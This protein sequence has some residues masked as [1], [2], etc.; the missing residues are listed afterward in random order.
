MVAVT[1]SEHPLL[2]RAIKSPKWLITKR[3]AFVLRPANEFRAQAEED[4]SVLLFTNCT[5][6]VCDVGARKCVGEFVLKTEAVIA[7]GWRVVKDDP[8]GARPRLKHASILGLPLHGSDELLIEMA[9]S[10]LV[11]LIDHIQ[12]RPSE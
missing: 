4:L 3:A 9:A 2:Y 6:A 1:A 5:K 7:D 10:R 8:T 11:K 12:P